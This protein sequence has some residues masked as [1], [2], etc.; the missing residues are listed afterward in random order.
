VGALEWLGFK[1]PEQ[2]EETLLNLVAVKA[3]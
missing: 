3:A 1:V 2:R